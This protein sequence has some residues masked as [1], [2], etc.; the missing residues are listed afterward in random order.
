MRCG[1]EVNREAWRYC[2]VCGTVLYKSK[3]VDYPESM[4]QGEVTTHEPRPV[5]GEEAVVDEQNV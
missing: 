3:T 5:G 1:T 2:P 4:K